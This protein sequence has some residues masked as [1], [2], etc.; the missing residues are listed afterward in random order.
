[1]RHGGRVEADARAKVE[2]PLVQILVVV[3]NN[4]A[5]YLKIEVGKG[6]TVTVIVCGLAGPKV[7]G[8]SLPCECLTVLT[9]S[10]GKHVNIH[11]L[12]IGI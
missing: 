5:R 12:C 4:Q 8:N 1:M 6:S 7:C 10:K 2:R 11:V 3:A 9:I